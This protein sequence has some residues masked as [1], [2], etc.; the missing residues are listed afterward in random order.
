MTA[1]QDR[2]R[3]SPTS[4]IMREAAN[5]IDELVVALEWNAAALQAACK[6]PEPIREI[7]DIT[8]MG[9]TRTIGKVLDMADSALQ[10]ES[11]E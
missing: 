5:R 3:A 1:L 10:G 8:I 9:K 11:N 7:G 2:L 6:M 4:E